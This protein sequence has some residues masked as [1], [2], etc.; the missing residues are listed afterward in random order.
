M[1]MI[2]TVMKMKMMKMKKDKMKM[3]MRFFYRVPSFSTV[4]QPCVLVVVP[5][6]VLRTMAG[7]T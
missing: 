1:M 5:I 6:V 4:R 3:M 7:F 2:V